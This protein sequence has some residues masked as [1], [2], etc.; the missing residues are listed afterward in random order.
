MR[1]RGI[2]LDAYSPLGVPDAHAFPPGSDPARGALSPT[3]LQDPVIA[4]IAAD[5][6][7]A[8]PAQVVFAWLWSQ[9]I[10]SVPRSQ[11]TTHMRDN[12]A[13][14]GVG[15]ATP[16]SLTVIE[17]AA[18]SARPQ[19]MCADDPLWYECAPTV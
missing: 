5:H 14:F 12:L 2:V 4:A 13:V 9:G 16:L 17:M 7:P 3:T 1:E 15:G 19:N 18:M 8:S 6:A 11:N 10:P